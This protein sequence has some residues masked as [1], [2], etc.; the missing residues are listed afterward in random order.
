[1]LMKAR[2]FTLIELMVTIAILAIIAAIAVPIYSGQ[3]EKARR[4][5]AVSSLLD[6]AQQLERCFTRNS[7]YTHANCPSGTIASADGFYEITVTAASTT[8]DLTAKPLGSQAGDDCKNFTLDHLGN[9][10]K[11]GTAD[12]CWGN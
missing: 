8:Y 9:K 2:G 1:M 11:T 3:V 6:T 10:G 5:D 4:A 7:S 12:R